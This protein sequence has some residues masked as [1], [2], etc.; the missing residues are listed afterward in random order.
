[1]GRTC[2][3][4]SHEDVDE[5]NKLLLS[6]TSF[7][8]IAGQFDLSK[9]A[10]A[11][12]KEGHIPEMLSKSKDLKE[13]TNADSLFASVEEEAGF[14]REMRDAA[15]A[16]GD[17]EL[18]LKAVDRALKCIEL[19]AKVE[20]LIREQP[21]VNIT[22]DAEWIELKSVIVSALKPYPDA[23]EAVRNAIK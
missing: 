16:E 20:G 2:T 3:V 11:R 12:H 4:C 17:I 15:K 6:G 22:L 23:L 19:Y 8:D 21:T 13:A 1:M 7:R 14:V 10:L 9:T 5:I 18:A